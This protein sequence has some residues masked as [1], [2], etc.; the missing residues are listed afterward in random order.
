MSFG[1]TLRQSSIVFRF[2]SLADGLYQILI[3][4]QKTASM[5]NLFLVYASMSSKDVSESIISL[6]DEQHVVY[7]NVLRIQKA[8]HTKKSSAN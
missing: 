5:G 1:Y 6:Y 3:L 7:D 8:K 2:I 4:L